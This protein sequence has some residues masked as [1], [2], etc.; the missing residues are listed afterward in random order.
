M[1]NQDVSVLPYS[2]AFLVSE[3]L[4]L[5][6]EKVSR[7]HPTVSEVITVTD[8]AAQWWI[9]IVK[10]RTNGGVRYNLFQK[11][12]VF[13]IT[14]HNSICRV[15]CRHLRDRGRYC[16]LVATVSADASAIFMLSKT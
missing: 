7:F 16:V 9:R 8:Y 2:T 13:Q 6:Y 3:P 14:L 5:L 10:Y 4:L 15:I 1:R 11:T 12:L